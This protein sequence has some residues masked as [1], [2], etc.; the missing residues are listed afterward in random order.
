MNEICVDDEL[1]AVVRWNVGEDLVELTEY[2]P[3]KGV[4]HPAHTRHYINGKLRM[5]IDQK[6]SVIDGPVDWIATPSFSPRHS[7]PMR[8]QDPGTMC[9]YTR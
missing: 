1:G 2:F 8:D 6:F 4:L 7:G 5:E 9:K 3:L